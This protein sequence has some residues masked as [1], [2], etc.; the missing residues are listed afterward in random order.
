MAGRA[1]RLEVRLARRRLRDIGLLAAQR[2]HV[3]DHVLDAR[4]A[5]HGGPRRHRRDAAA[6]NGRDHGV[7]V[8][9]PLPV[10][11]AQ[12][13]EADGAATVRAVALS[14]VL[15]EQ[16]VRRRHRLLVVRELGDGQR[17]ERSQQRSG[18]RF[19][20]RPFL[21]VLTRLGPAANTG[22]IAEA[23]EVRQVQKP[24]RDGDVEQPQPPLRQRVVV[25]AQV[26]V[27]D[28]PGVGAAADLL[29]CGA[30]LRRPAQQP[31]AGQDVCDRQDDDEQAPTSSHGVLL[32]ESLTGGSSS[33]GMRASTSKSALRRLL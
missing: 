28:V 20:R 16:V 26:L 5:D 15:L 21:L 18:T 4:L 24:E 2:L 25:F 12:V 22:E 7:R 19:H 31:E 8:A 17:G 33:S 30:R 29:A 9:A 10:G 14:A 3:R 6:G 13:R 27:P 32:P 11:V 23:R 1:Q